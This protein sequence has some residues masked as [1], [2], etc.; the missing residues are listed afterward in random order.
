[1]EGEKLVSVN[2]VAKNVLS[3][4][5][6]GLF[7][8]HELNLIA[9]HWF[10]LSVTEDQFWKIQCKLEAKQK[11]FGCIK[12]K[13]GCKSAQERMKMKYIHCITAS[14]V[15]NQSLSTEHT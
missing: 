2:K 12:A 11:M 8:I 15:N 4:G 7:Q 5:Q 9:T 1:M 3:I 10:M 13:T 6:F 14:Y